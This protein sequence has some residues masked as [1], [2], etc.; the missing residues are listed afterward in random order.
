V[1]EAPT[2]W[3]VAAKESSPRRP[4]TI[5]ANRFVDHALANVGEPE[6]ALLALTG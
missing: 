5:A 4:H 3:G 6:E 2:D 1:V